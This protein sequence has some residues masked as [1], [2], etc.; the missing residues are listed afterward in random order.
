MQKRQEKE[1][2]ES[3]PKI[4]EITDDEALELQ[5]DIDKSKGNGPN[6]NKEE[7]NGEKD[8]KLVVS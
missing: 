5:A 8:T 6:G 2:K 4:Q 7:N 3:E 1:K